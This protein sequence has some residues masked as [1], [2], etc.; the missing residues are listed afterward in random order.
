MKF[1]PQDIKVQF[2]NDEFKILEKIMSEYRQFCID[3][4]KN[5]FSNLCI[6]LFYNISI[7]LQF[8][9]LDHNSTHA[10]LLSAFARHD[11]STYPLSVCYLV[12]IVLRE[13]KMGWRTR[14]TIEG[15]CKRHREGGEGK[16]EGRGSYLST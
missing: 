16:T 1:S 8:I 5:K 13:F 7:L 3:H 14:E 12:R 9:S 2:L 15:A 10:L 6:H 11:G 4:S